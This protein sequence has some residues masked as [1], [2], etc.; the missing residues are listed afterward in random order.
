[1]MKRLMVFTLCSLLMIINC[2][3]WNEERFET[4]TDQQLSKGFQDFNACF[5]Q[6]LLDFAKKS[7]SEALQKEV[8]TFL[9]TILEKK[10]KIEV[11]KDTEVRPVYVSAQGDF[12]RT[13]AYFMKSGEIHHL[14]GIIHT[15]TPATPLCSKGEISSGLVDPSMKDQKRL[16][17]VMKRPHLIRMFL[18]E[19]GTLIAAYPTKGKE[20]RTDQQLT[21]YNEI[22]RNHPKTL[23]DL[24]L[25]CDELQQDMVGATYLFCTADGDWMSF[26]IRAS[27]AN[28]PEDD[29]QWEMWFGPLR[30]SEIS[31]RVY[32][33]IDYLNA[34][35]S[36]DL[37][38][39]LFP[40]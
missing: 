25:K 29:R 26:G 24:P 16:F 4:I 21:I 30:D 22:C 33:T 28:A 38:D 10:F 2:Y 39:L 32:K 7:N 36:R 3:G 9:N 15:P 18:A 37:S 40:S 14:V 13:M 5:K 17:T 11:G 35:Q 34:V 20:K 8:L 31:K 1:M 27:Q 19:G 12:E 23:I 6:E